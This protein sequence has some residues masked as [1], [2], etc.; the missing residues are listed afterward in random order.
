[1]HGRPSF[2]GEWPVAELAD[3]I[4]TPGEGQLRGMLVW[5]GN[6][7]L[8]TPDGRRVEQALRSLELLVSVDFYVNETAAHAHYVLPPVGP[9]ARPHYD[10]IFRMLAVRNTARFADAV[11]PPDG[12]LRQDWQIATGLAQ[13]LRRLRGGAWGERLAARALDWLGPTGVLDLGLRLGR[14]RL[15]V[16]ALRASPSGVDLGPL[17]PCWLERRPAGFRLDLCPAP[18]AA[19]LPRLLAAMAEPPPPLVLV[20]RRDLRSGNSWLHN[21]PRLMKGGARCTLQVH[22]DD[23]LRCG[24]TDGGQAELRSRVGAVVVP[25][26]VTTDVRPGVVSLPHGWGHGRE[27]V[28]WRLAHEHGGVSQNDVTD[29]ARVDMLTGNAAFNGTPVDLRAAR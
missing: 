27:G 26:E 13:R 14:S 11:L 29:A 22:P 5:A 21:A 3:E 24:V 17:R 16:S 4:L 25:V 12:D 15:S 18:F 10:V 23:A 9:L 7:V 6:P 2:G 8:S 28:G 20:G 1:V 19:D